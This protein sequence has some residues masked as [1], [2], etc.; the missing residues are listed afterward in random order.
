MLP[1]GLAIAQLQAGGHATDD[2]LVLDHDVGAHVRRRTPDDQ[3]RAHELSG[4]LVLEHVRVGHERARRV[5]VPSVVASHGA[6]LPQARRMPYDWP[7]A[8]HAASGPAQASG[9]GAG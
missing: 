9:H 7:G 3:Q 2:D 5:A 8:P 6:M 1:R 4:G